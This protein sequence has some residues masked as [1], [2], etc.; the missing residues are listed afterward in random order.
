[1]RIIRKAGDLKGI[2]LLLI[3]GSAGSM[4]VI[5]DILANLKPDLS[6][7]IV[8]ILHRKKSSDSSL[9]DY[10]NVKSKIEV[11][12]AEEKGD[13]LPG[14]VYL[15]PSDYHLLV[16]HDFTFSLDTSE[17]VQYSR[18]SIDV[19]FEAAAD[20]YG[21]SVAA[22]LLS[23]A[24]S[25]GAQGILAIANGGGIT[26]VQNPESAEVDYMPKA[27]IFKTVVDYILET[28]NLPAFVNK[29]SAA[30]LSE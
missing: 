17:K 8:I 15:A 10:F 19:T 23:G 5:T 12:E 2:K 20:A 13:I 24:N 9:T 30:Q 7:A 29:L 18:P 16:E 11:F 21:Q 1:M 28:H 4:G 25:D 14:R 22:L 6:L 3:G 26:V 27:A